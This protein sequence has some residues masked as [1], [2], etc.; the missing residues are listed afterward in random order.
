VTISAKVT[1]QKIMK[2]EN[3]IAWESSPSAQF[4][5][6]MK[7]ISRDRQIALRMCMAKRMPSV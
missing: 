1:T 6:A 5:P 2:L 7:A 4:A 3:S